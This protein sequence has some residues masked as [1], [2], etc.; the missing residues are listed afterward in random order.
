MHLLDILTLSTLYFTKQLVQQ[1]V[2][3]AIKHCVHQN[4][5]VTITNTADYSLYLNIVFFSSATSSF[6]QKYSIALLIIVTNMLFLKFNVDYNQYI[7]LPS[8]RTYTG[9]RGIYYIAR[10]RN[11]QN[12]TEITFHMSFQF[13]LQVVNRFIVA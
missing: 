6:H 7:G 12:P 5:T 11:F 2:L 3:L 9:R 4:Y 8:N 10:F 1:T 13:H